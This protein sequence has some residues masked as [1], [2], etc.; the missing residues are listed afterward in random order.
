MLVVAAANPSTVLDYVVATHPAPLQVTPAGAAAAPATISITAAA[1]A[2]MSVRLTSLSFIVCGGPGEGDLTEHPDRI[3]A[4]AVPGQGWVCTRSG[5]STI[6]A[7]P[8]E[9][10]DYVEVGERGLFF[11]L[12]NVAVNAEIGVTA[13][14]ILEE[15]RDDE[16]EAAEGRAEFHLGKCPPGFR[17]GG[18]RPTILDE[19]RTSPARGDYVTLAWHASRGAVYTMVHENTSY[20]V[21]AVRTWTTSRPLDRDSVFYLEARLT[22]DDRTVTDYLQTYVTVVNPDPATFRGGDRPRFDASGLAR[23]IRDHSDVPVLVIPARTPM[24]V[25]DKPGA[26]STGCLVCGCTPRTGEHPRPASRSGPSGSEERVPPDVVT[27]TFGALTVNTVSMEVRLH[28]REVDL[29][30]TQRRLLLEFVIEPGV[31]LSRSALLERVWDE[32]RGGDPRVVDVHVQRLRGKIG[33]ERIE[34][35]RGFGYKFRP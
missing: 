24:D 8:D 32:G 19:G 1:P 16:G 20:D 33:H 3:H 2:G 11:E 22:T 18:L 13:V 10:D 12:T 14:T 4:T 7:T 29:T 6:V 25:A 34:T 17:F 23:L 28:G 21:T 27:L 30:P 9:G 35:L 15:T 5:E 31:V 26:G